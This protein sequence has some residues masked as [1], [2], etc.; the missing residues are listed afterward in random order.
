[1]GEIKTPKPTRY[2]IEGSWILRVPDFTADPEY[3]NMLTGLLMPKFRHDAHKAR[4]EARARIDGMGR[5]QFLHGVREFIVR[6]AIDYGRRFPMKIRPDRT[7]DG[8]DPA[9]I[10]ELYVPYATAQG[11]QGRTDVRNLL[12]R[13]GK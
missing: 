1:M 8:F 5:S 9:K 3:E 12:V 7:L 10:A 6:T 13:M 4:T 2:V 11:R